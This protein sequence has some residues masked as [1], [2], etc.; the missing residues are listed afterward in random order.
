MGQKRLADK[1]SGIL[2]RI[3]KE[4]DHVDSKIGEA[5][6]LIDL[7]ND[8]MVWPLQPHPLFLNQ[9][10]YTSAPDSSYL[11]LLLVIRICCVPYCR[12][13]ARGPNN[14]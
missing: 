10:R 9:F 11:L 1:V 12:S 6:H 3:E 8:G 5:M 13:Q 7:D 4:L 2:Q 14:A